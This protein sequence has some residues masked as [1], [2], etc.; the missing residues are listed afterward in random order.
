MLGVVAKKPYHQTICLPFG[1]DAIGE[2]ARLFVR[3]PHS[4]FNGLSRLHRSKPHLSLFGTS[5]GTVGKP[6]C[7]AERS[8]PFPEL[9]LG[10]PKQPRYCKRK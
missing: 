2:L 8:T 3:S 5:E 6:V 1:N 9:S 4:H 10:S 7:H